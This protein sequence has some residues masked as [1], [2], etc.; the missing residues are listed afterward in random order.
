VKQPQTLPLAAAVAVA[1]AATVSPATADLQVNHHTRNALEFGE[2]STVAIVGDGE[3]ETAEISALDFASGCLY[4]TSA[5]DK[6]L[7]VLRVDPAGKLSGPLASITLPGGPNGV[8]AR[9]GLVAV[10]VEASPKTNNGQV[11]FYRVNAVDCALTSD[12]AV[13]VGA[14]PDMLTFTPDGKKILVANE[15]EP[16]ADYTIDPEGSVSIIDVFSR[17]V[18]NADFRRFN[19]RALKDV[20]I[21]GPNATVAQDLEPEYIAVS[22]D[23]RTA[24]VT[25]QENNAIAIV[26]IAR[27]EVTDVVGLG[28]KAHAEEPNGFDASDRDGGINI[29]T[30]PVKGMYQPDA[31]A[32][33]Q[34]GNATFLVTANE[35]DARDYAGFREE[36]TVSRLIL[37]P[38]AFPNADELKEEANLGRL[39]VTRAN[40]DTDGDGDYDEIYAFG[41]RSFS[42][43]N[44]QARM[45]Y[46]SGA[47]FETLTAQLRP[48]EF[49]SQYRGTYPN[50]GY[51]PEFDRRSDN[52]GPE[53][54]A[55]A[56]GELGGV[57]YAF[58]GLE[59]VG[60]I[61]AYSL[62][63]P[64]A[65]RFVSY[66][67][68]SRVD[69]SP[70][71][72]LFV[73]RT[74]DSGWLIVT[75]EV[76][77]TVSVWP[78]SARR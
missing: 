68:N 4:T 27:A 73:P 20:R 36:T 77:G 39:T 1:I 29:R 60:G 24:Y 74:P 41:G 7:A 62:S 47:D 35:G 61:F 58:V 71:G 49:N 37:D 32:A 13:T 31:I 44:R 70:E 28:F 75:S 30:W 34:R 14:L 66:L 10:A 59:R 33:F 17:A 23:S 67:D 15:G 64:S 65:P 25:L 18:A 22:P 42:V 21:F 50:G 52:K 19:G 45:V 48:T 78:V 69:V 5:R 53:P 16:N 40:G 55:I 54:E 11:L 63:S 8:A 9:N 43:L 3:A 6:A 72:L 46:D 38:A 76:S 57:T 51:V 26:D 12:G 2:G 56:V